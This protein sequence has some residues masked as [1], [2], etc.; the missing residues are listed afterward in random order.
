MGGTCT[1]CDGV[2]VA[3]KAN[4]CYVPV[5]TYYAIENYCSISDD[6]REQFCSSQMGGD[7][8]EWGNAQTISEFPACC[9]MGPS[10]P[11]SNIYYGGGCCNGVSIACGGQGVQCARIGFTGNPETCCF[12]DLY[13]TADPTDNPPECYSDKGKTHTCS[14][15]SGNTPN[16]R[17]IVSSDCQNPL[18]DYCT[19]TQSGDN[20]NSTEWM[21]RW[22][23][24]SIL[25]EANCTYAVYRNILHTGG[26][27]HCFNPADFKPIPGICNIDSPLPLDP[28]GF[29]WA[30][31]LM[32]KV[33]QRY[34]DQGFVIGALP[35]TKGFNEFQDLIFENICCPY[36]GLCQE[37]L[38]GVCSKYNTQNLISN[39]ELLGWC[40]CH[41]NIEEY[42]PYS[43][44]YNIQAQCAPT[45]NR[46][47]VIPITGIDENPIR[48]TQNICIIDNTTT[49]IINSTIGGNVN[50]N[51]VCGGCDVGGVGQCSCLVDNTT[52][53]VNNSTI[54]GNFVPIA[55]G[56]GSYICT[57]PNSSS[58]GPSTIQVPC[59]DAGATNPFG[60]YD[61][62]VK[63][64]EERMSFAAGFWTLMIVL[65]LG[66]VII[67]IALYL[68]FK[69]K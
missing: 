69:T 37:A 58:L 46:Q 9:A 38:R 34:E 5:G 60:N 35:G 16:Y 32:N 53:D 54:G 11:D 7:S 67:I 49:E 33:L 20:P 29:Y 44:K 56:C 39:P 8:G 48:C 12:N 25:E 30:S 17:S 6:Y 52:I 47:G 63:Q 18:S 59:S 45:C 19:G 51:Q 27:G 36:P 1:A 3:S 21:N 64:D 43:K 68:V 14:D 4:Q 10:G 24:D 61:Q 50:F 22:Q 57:V 66:F 2:R 13:C 41:M 23:T 62:R 28:E 55:E 65:G 15:G 26:T 42:E 31:L 40:G